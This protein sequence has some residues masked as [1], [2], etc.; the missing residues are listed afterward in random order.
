M[1]SP[2]R[3]H[4][5]A[6]VSRRTLLLVSVAAGAVLA[7]GLVAAMIASTGGS[8]TP[9]ATPTGAAR[10]AAMLGGIPQQGAALGSPSAPVTLVEFADVQCPYC[11]E[12]AIRALPGIVSQYVRTG[13]VR[14]LFNGMA[15]V[16]PDSE[17]AL[18][19]AAAA[20][21][22]GRFWNVLEL[23]FENQGGENSGWATDSL[24]RSIGDA[25]AGARHG[26]MLDAQRIGGGDPG[27]GARHRARA[28]GR[29]RARHRASRSARRAER[30][31]SCGS[32]RSSRPG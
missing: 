30:C 16:G 32:R 20:G 21:Q 6:S 27:A 10:V 31:G 23:L 2:G 12:W 29:G 13:K 3:A 1:R 4:D 22:Q 24:L 25:V 17:T 26:K 8:E 11:A 19:T 5:G 28:A 9:A 18:R 14:I 15:F 7:G